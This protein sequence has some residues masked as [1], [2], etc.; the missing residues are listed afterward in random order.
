MSDIQEYKISINFSTKNADKAKDD[1]DKVKKSV[2]ALKGTT[3]AS[4]LATAGIGKLTSS[5]G[6]LTKM[7]KGFVAVKTFT[8]L[9]ETIF[10]LGGKMAD[11]IET[12]NLFR[13]SMGEAASAA[14]EFIA[15]AESKLGLDNQQLRNSISQFYNLAQG[16]GIADDR[17]YTMSQNLTQ[18]AGD[19]SSFA[20]ISFETA[21]QKLMSG[22]SGQVKP[23]REYGIAL[24]QATLQ[25]KAYALGINEKVKNM[26][27]AQKTELIYYQIMSSTQKMQGDLGRSLLSPANSIRVMQT[28]FKALARAVGSIFIPIMMKIIPVVRVV[29]QI[30]TQAAQAIANLLGFE[31]TDFNAD[32]GSVGNLLTGVSDDIG[33]VG[34]AA[35]DTTKKLNKM[36]MPFDELNNVNFDTGSSSGGAGAGGIGDGGSLGLEL[37][38]YDM[39]ASMSESMDTTISNIK[40]TLKTLFEPVQNS[41]NTYGQGVMDSF[42]YALSESFRLS[43]D[44]AGSLMDVWSNGTGE[45]TLNTIWQILTNIFYTIGNI[46][47]A[48]ATAWETDGTGTQIIQNLWDG[49]NNLLGIINSVAD[50]IKKFT[51]SPDFQ[52]FANAM[53]NIIKSVSEVFK[54][55]TEKAKEIW[56]GGLKGAFE[57]LLGLFTRLGEIIDVIWNQA[58]KPI[59]DWII[60]TLAPIISG[61][62]KGFGAE[63]EMI[64]GWIDVLMG[65]INGDWQRVWDGFGKVFDGWKQSFEGA[66]EA[67]KGV[68]EGFGQWFY[69]TF[70]KSTVD[71]FNASKDELKASWDKIKNAMETAKNWIND[72]IIQPI[73]TFFENLGTGIATTW[74]NIKNGITTKIN[75]IKTR[76][77]TTFNTIKEKITGPIDRAKELI[78]TAIENIKGFFKFEWEFPHIKT[79]HLSWSTQPAP[80]WIANI[81]RAINLP[82]EIPKLNVSW[83]AEGGFPE[84]GEL[85]F[86]NEAGP[87]MIGQIGNRTAIAN[88][89]Q[90]T[91]AIA[92]A[93]YNAISRALA[94]NRSSDQPAVI[95]VNLGNEQLYKG[96]GQYKNEQSNMYGINI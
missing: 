3:S 86:M 37:P 17:A 32:L 25:E 7:L 45:T 22:I 95:Q 69:N 65:L 52:R 74:D 66:W 24:D 63:I 46:K 5:F 78:H 90:I 59:V 70:L 4:K 30:L 83:Y 85:F 16:I 71:A 89:D 14:E 62:G 94:E 80:G 23:L 12:V 2:G 13:A 61:I 6:G 56:E 92:N 19:L 47:G 55:I 84:M 38:T 33:G 35:E 21:Q 64:N 77:E 53:M 15:D 76:V 27:R 82:A 79:P 31:M 81:L 67:L 9:G 44:I 11:Y 48:F 39:F 57:Q 93:A 18:L 88:Q 28:E 50:S 42:N 26:T 60:D 34:D 1:I 36:L 54:K 96:Y 49:F 43:G 58:L 8:K 20:N 68:L 40:E 41:W 10:S 73:K 87:E 91:T 51:E 75:E 29:T 72:H